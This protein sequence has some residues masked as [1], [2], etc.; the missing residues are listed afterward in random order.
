MRI[1]Q[2]TPYMSPKMGGPVNGLT[3]MC[4]EMIRL[5]HDVVLFSTDHGFDMSD[6]YNLKFIESLKEFNT[7]LFKCRAGRI[8][9]APAMGRRFK[10]D[11]KSFDIVHIHDYRVYPSIA[12]SHY[13]KKYGVPLIMQPHG[14]LPATERGRI[15]KKIFDFLFG[16]NII[17]SANGFVAIS[18]MEF[19]ILLKKN[20]PQGKVCLI[21]EPIDT[22]YYGHLPARGVFRRKF[23]LEG[24]VILYLGRIHESKKI[25]FLIYGFKELLRLRKDVSL[26][27]AGPDFGYSNRLK[28]LAC[29]L[30][31]SERVFFT[32]P[33][34]GVEKRE[35]YVDSDVVVYPRP[36]EVFGQVPF[37]AIMCGKP[38]IVSENDG[39]GYYMQKISEDFVVKYNDATALRDKLNYLLENPEK[40]NKHVSL[41]K[42]YI[43]ENLTPSYLAR[44]TEDLY[45]QVIQ[46]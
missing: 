29:E 39:C 17:K 9:Y 6:E 43:K 15:R 38:V 19:R 12:A 11:L 40:A 21:P 3:N 35:A 36:D 28:R 18:P 34:F 27:I 24:K 33:L 10:S 2:V 42:D 46:D 1:L 31:L 13:A 7:T 44:K 23:N 30:G 8:Y 14:T 32:G 5:G 37:E 25:G 4:R 20:I 22:A 16:D 45:R 41:G 26:V